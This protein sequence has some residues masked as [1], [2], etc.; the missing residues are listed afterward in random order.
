MDKGGLECLKRIYRKS[1]LR[2]LLSQTETDM[3]TFLK[4][5]DI[6][7]VIEKI[8][9]TWDQI[10]T[11]T[12]RKSWGRLIP[13]GEA[14]VDENDAYLESVSNDDF[15][16]QFEE[17]NIDIATSDIDAWFQTDGPG[18]EHMDDQSIIDLV[19][20]DD[21]EMIYEDEEEADD[22]E[23]TEQQLKCSVSHAEAFQ[24]FDQCLIW[25]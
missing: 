25:L 9:I 19:S 16:K 5:I 18:Y 21:G 15:V 17:L 13:I 7:R 23:T 3:L 4:K 10:S 22:L 2:E 6:L 11:E 1:V 12:I 20:S 24:M 8:A 14:S